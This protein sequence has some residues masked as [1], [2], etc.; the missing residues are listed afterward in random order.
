[1]IWEGNVR[2]L[3]IITLVG[4]TNLVWSATNDLW[5][6]TSWSDRA[7]NLGKHK[8]QA[9]SEDSRDLLAVFELG[10]GL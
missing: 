3:A 1:M 2:D 6:A 8:L 9:G 7:T 5:S 10:F 4:A